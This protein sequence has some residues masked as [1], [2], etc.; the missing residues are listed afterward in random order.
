MN[1]RSCRRTSKPFRLFALLLIAL[2][3]L[4]EGCGPS[5]PP[6]YPVT[7]KVSWKGGSNFT[8]GVI[9]FLHK[10]QPEIIAIGE[11]GQ[12]GSFPVST[13]MYG[14]DKPGAPVGEYTVLVQDPA[15]NVARDGQ[16]QIKPMVVTTAEFKV[17]AKDSNDFNVEVVQ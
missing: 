12:D 16:M 6:C 14:K 3:P 10:E 13:K 8:A 4:V 1:H 17:E 15:K 7:G 5:I 11:I 2:L 9:T